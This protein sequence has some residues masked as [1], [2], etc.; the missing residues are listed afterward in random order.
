MRLGADWVAWGP[1]GCTGEGCAVPQLQ[2]GMERDAWEPLREGHAGLLDRERVAPLVLRAMPSAKALAAALY[3]EA[4]MGMRRATRRLRSSGG[5]RA[6]RSGAVTTSRRGGGWRTGRTSRG[7]ARA[8]TA[9]RM[10]AD[11]EA[12]EGDGEAAFARLT[13]ALE[14]ARLLGARLALAKRSDLEAG[15]L[16]ANAIPI[17]RERG[18]HA[19]V[20]RYGRRLA[21]LLDDRGE[22]TEAVEV[23]REVLRAAAQAPGEAAVVQAEIELALA[24]FHREGRPI[25]SKRALIWRRREGPIRRC[26][27]VSV[28]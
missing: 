16:R 23:R 20:A 13:A 27:R 15:V 3:G 24:L 26:H 22:R 19:A 25:E 6:A 2:L 7:E 18:E 12:S 5:S 9:E 11:I 8:L 14:Y 17:A 28:A 21:A 10:L 4:A 1:A